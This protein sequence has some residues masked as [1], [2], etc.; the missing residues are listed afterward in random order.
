MRKRAL[1]ESDNDLLSPSKLT[2]PELSI[3]SQGKQGRDE[4]E[5][6]SPEVLGMPVVKRAVLDP[7]PDA[8]VV[9]A[10]QPLRRSLRVAKR[11]LIE[12]EPGPSRKRARVLPAEQQLMQMDALQCIFESL[13]I[14]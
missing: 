7:T 1:E 9:G 13:S 3:Q 4:S 14:Q 5:D 11:N 8:L 12:P 2:P 6:D 10:P